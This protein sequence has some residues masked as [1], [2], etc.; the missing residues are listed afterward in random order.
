MSNANIEALKSTLRWVVL[1]VGSFI[2]SEL[3]RQADLIPESWLLKIFIF[4]FAIPVRTLF[5]FG[6]TL[7]GGYV[8]KYLHEVKKESKAYPVGMTPAGGLLPF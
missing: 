4:T 5:I 1:F 7:I 8:D 2:I 6:L 3:I